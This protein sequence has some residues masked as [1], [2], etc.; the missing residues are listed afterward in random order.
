MLC[1]AVLC[2]HTNSK[3]HAAQDELDEDQA[4]LDEQKE[5]LAAREADLATA[6]KDLQERE[7][8]V[9]QTQDTLQK[10]QVSSLCNS[11]GCVASGAPRRRQGREESERGCGCLIV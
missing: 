3:F 5:Q 1:S 8:A 7:A 10:Q 2:C 9:K 4:D 11:S 6:Q